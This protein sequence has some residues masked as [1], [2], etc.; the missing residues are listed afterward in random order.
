MNNAL[1]TLKL[2]VDN[3][4]S[5]FTIK[6]VAEAL[7]MNYRIAHE[8]VT[9]LEKEG[10][11]KVTKIGNSKVCEFSYVF[12]SRIAEIEEIR[13]SE[14]FKN[15]D[16]Q[17][18]Y[19]RIKEVESPFY[20]LALFGSYASKTNKK[21]SDIDL[22]LVTD[23]P[24]INRKTNSVISLLPMNIHLLEFTSQEF[25]AMLRNKN[26][27]VGNE[28]VKNNIILYGIESFYELISHA[29]Q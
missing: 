5:K 2:F 14:L 23:Y 8:E 18:M 15:K 1:K 3:K 9:K 26:F 4:D 27:N 24:E 21:H 10:L 12:D 25:L 13:K 11:I 28:I 17:V 29:K 20:C 22:C 6:K 7:E 16:L 19:L